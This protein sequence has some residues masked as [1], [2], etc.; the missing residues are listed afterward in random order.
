MSYEKEKEELKKFLG[1]GEEMPEVKS[2]GILFDGKQYSV[3]IPRKFA[4]I[5]KIDIKKDRMEFELKVP[6]IREMEKEPKL[7]AKFKRGD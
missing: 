2:M 6:S 3:R 7:V 4:D 5:L 1:T